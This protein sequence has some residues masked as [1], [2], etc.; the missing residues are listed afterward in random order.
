MTWRI[1]GP[2][3]HAYQTWLLFSFRCLDVLRSAITMI[4]PVV[5]NMLSLPAGG[6][7]ENSEYISSSILPDIKSSPGIQKV[8]F[9]RKKEDNNIGVLCTGRPICY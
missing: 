8:F 9:G 6:D 2:R 7:R 3:Q 1:V 4:S 5:F